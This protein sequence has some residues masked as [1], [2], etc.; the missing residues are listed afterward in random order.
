MVTSHMPLLRDKSNNTQLTKNYSIPFSTPYRKT[1]FSSLKSLQ[2]H[3]T[4][5]TLHPENIVYIQRL[6]GKLKKPFNEELL[7]ATLK[8]KFNV[9]IV[10][11]A[12][13]T[14]AEQIQVS[15]GCTA[16]VGV[17]GAG[18]ANMVFMEN[19]ASVLDIV[20]S[21]QCQTL[22]SLRWLRLIGLKYRSMNCVDQQ[23]ATKRF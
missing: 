6:S 20:P 10:D 11:F 19:S 15:A 16:M 14:F 17:H 22:E 23:Y 8:K 9:K 21:T 12:A 1:A 18:M 13:L 3:L 4:Q 2:Q 7:I 5:K